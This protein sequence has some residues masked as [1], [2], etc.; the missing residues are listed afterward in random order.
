MNAPLTAAGRF[1]MALLL[2]AGLGL[3]YGFLRPLRRK[4]VHLADMLFLP[5]MVVAWL[6]LSFAVC[7]GDL[8]LAYT[9]GLLVGAIVWECTL[10]QLLRPVFFGLWR[11]LK[12]LAGLILWPFGKIFKKTVD[13]LKILFA[14]GKKRSTIK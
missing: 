6:Y 9:A 10:G 7:R 3:Y 5:G 2:G 4:H 13:F 8:R 11:L 14:I 12:T 1:A